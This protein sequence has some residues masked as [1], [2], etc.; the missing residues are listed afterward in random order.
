MK[1]S[2]EN[3]FDYIIVGAG[4]AGCA[5]AARLSENPNVSVCLLEAGGPDKSVF[6][7]APVGVA[8][9][10]PTKINNWAFETIPQPGLNGRK[11][12]QPR[13]KTLGGS[14]STNAMLYVRGNQW[15]YDN[16][17]ALGNEGWAYK[18]I[19]PYFKKSE[20]NEE[21]HDSY[22][23]S[24]GP[25]GV[26]NATDASNLN[27]MF[28]NSCQQHGIKY[29]PDYNGADQN[30]AFMYQRTIKNGERCSA[31]KAFLTPNMNRDNLTVITHALTEK[32]LLEGKKAIGVRYQKNSMTIDINC[33]EE[34][35]LSSGAFG[36]PQILM[37][38]GIGASKH[39]NEK[40]IT[41]VHDLPGVG[42]NLQDHIDYVQTYKVD[43]S[44]DTFGLS[45]KGGTSMLKSMFEW[46]RNRTGKITSTLAES[47]A[48]FSTE[49]Y[50]VAPDAQFVFVPGIVD[51]HARKVNW[52]H[53][54]S[55]HITVLRPESVGEVKLHSINPKDSLLI[56]PK[57]LSHKKDMEVIINGAKKMQTILEGNPFDNIRKGM[58]YHVGNDEQLT[59]DIRTRA[60]TQY[61]P[62]GTCKMGT[63]ADKMAVVDT[64][65]KV[66]GMQGLR[67]AD[68]SIMP[69]IVSGNTNA[70]T[71]MIG[72]KAADM[73]LANYEENKKHA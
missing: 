41:C 67:V 29:N 56:D 61:H 3:T 39:L 40:D 44:Q 55:C 34:V 47:G 5:L 27:D 48:F 62:C 43:S 4:S 68:A 31:A 49:E 13:G 57:Y 20:G 15:D 35:I 66:Y 45:V 37:L 64:N 65:L 30:G 58:L 7:H 22:H 46:K 8:A 12:Y 11:G 2:Q 59:Q 50:T 52:G 21:F 26:S 6:I 69:K 72:E 10:L 38:S 70:P 42:Q 23:G 19:L 63:V 16:W 71:I 51:D 25:L 9:M 28:I 53:G 24:N 36:S 33:N 60:D 32:I 73:I 54:Y 17:A 1:K 14:S 18:D